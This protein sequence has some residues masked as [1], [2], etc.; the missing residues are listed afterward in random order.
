MNYKIHRFQS[1]DMGLAVNA[2]AV[3]TQNGV[4]AID[5]TLL[6]SDSE[7]FAKLINN[8][9]KPILGIL[10]T[11]GHPD[12]IAGLTT[13]SQNN[14]PPIFATQGVVDLMHE[15][16]ADKHAQWSGMFGDDWISKWT[17]PNHI[18]KDGETLEFDGV[19]FTCYDIGGGGDCEANAIWMLESGTT[20][21]FIGDLI[22]NQNFTYMN[23]GQ[24]LRWLAN[25][26]RYQSLL[27]DAETLYIGHGPEGGLEMIGQQK[28][29]LNDYCE[30]LLD[31][32]KGA[33]VLDENLTNEF[34]AK[35]EKKYPSYGLNFMLGLSAA[36]V[37]SELA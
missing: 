16:E 9:G 14:Q 6:K 34:I 24:I 28:L 4:V 31:T 8:I 11:H 19:K 18:V 20:Q 33:G 35:M 25:L 17:Y 5:A 26:D 29:Y 1:S 2:Y 12:H 15:T 27:K 10:I 7:A 3:E 30:T 36:K 22:Y 13:L 37:A 21:A 23:D 32:T